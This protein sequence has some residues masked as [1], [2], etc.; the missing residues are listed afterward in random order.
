MRG[1]GETVRVRLSDVSKWSLASEPF[2]EGS[3]GSEGLI[4]SRR[5]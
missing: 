4:R 1:D 5:A 2:V 3:N